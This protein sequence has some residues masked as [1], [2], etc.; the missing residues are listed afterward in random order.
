[1][2]CLR[3]LNMREREVMDTIRKATPE[4]ASRIAEILIFA[5]RT[6]YRSIF[7][8]DKVSFGEMQVY[9]LAKEYIDCPDKLQNIWVYDDE[10]VKEF[11]NRYEKI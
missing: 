2:I 7:C 4:D 1:M 9:P 3:N 5:K 6:N 11:I 8:N 10:F